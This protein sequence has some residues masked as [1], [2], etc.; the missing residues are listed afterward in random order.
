MTDKPLVEEK[1]LSLLGR[2]VP[3]LGLIAGYK[4][5]WLRPDLVAGGVL[6]AYLLPAGIADASLANLP[7]EAGLYS[8]LFAGLVFW[9]F[10]SSRHTVI[11]TTSAI[12]L[13]VGASLGDMAGGEPSRFAAMAACVAILVGVMSLATWLLRAGVVI[14]FV[15]ETV[16]VGFKCGIALF[17]ASSQCPKLFGFAGSHGT[18]LDRVS[19]FIIH[20][21]ESN[22]ASVILG[23]IALAVLLLGKRFLKSVPV[24]L[25]VVVAGIVISSMTRMDQS[26][27]KM[28]GEVP[29][30]LPRIGLPA[31]SLEEINNLLPLAMACFLLS[32][33]ETS[34]IGRMFALKH[35]YKYDP[36]QEFLA[37]AAANL[38]AGAGRGFP[39]SGGMSQSLVN[40]TGGARTPISG[41]VAALIVL[42]VAVFASGL[43]K[44]LPQ[45]V[46]AA[47]VL[48]AVTGLVSV[49][50]LKRMWAFSRSEFL[51]SMVAMAGVLEAGILRGVLI[52][53][54]LSLLLLL[55]RASHPHTTELG[56]VPG[57]DY[58]ADR[59]RHPENQRESA[60]FVFR[61]ESALL[62]FNAEYV[63]DRFLELLEQCGPDVRLAV[64]F[65]GS[66][67]M[68]DLAGAEMLNELRRSLRERGIELCLAEVHGQVRESLRRANP[69]HKWGPIEA[70]QTVLSVINQWRSGTQGA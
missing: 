49:T 12:S 18:F 35:N 31:I 42:A 47:V 9:L 55:R 2:L 24:A 16:L 7:S 46:L 60:A 20:L 38:A 29:Q 10:C 8:C 36:N 19:Y 1:R 48:S 43:L 63:R 53:A 50:A 4:R 57:T 25:I 17:L 28:L 59:V 5:E 26:G 65:L 56:R 54:L 58:F 21:G 44:N 67:P 11:T 22:K 23:L 27:V 40:E 68:V 15:S 14:N 51:V 39:V 61:V 32:A 41:V 30:G 3:G 70:N 34:A 13:L 37:L 64:F 33:V 45:P 52:G 69:E 6:A 62:Y 66:V